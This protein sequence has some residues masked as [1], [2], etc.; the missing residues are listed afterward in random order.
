M[1]NNEE[2][3]KLGQKIIQTEIDGVI[4]LRDSLGEEFCNVCNLLL[5]AKGRVILTGMG[6]SG[7]IA[8]KITATMASTGTPALFVHP[9]EALHGDLGMI[10]KN[11]I[12]IAISNSG[13]TVELQ[14]IINYAIRFNIPLIGITSNKDS[15]LGKA[16]TYCLCLPDAKEAC[17]LGLAPTTSTTN[18]LVLGDAI[19]IALLEMKGFSPEDFR[20]FHPGGS[21]GSKLLKITDVM[22]TG[23]SIPLVISGTG[24][25][26]AIIE[27]TSHKFGCVGVINSS[28]EI[29]GII[30]DGDIRRHMSDNF[31]NK[32][33]DDVMTKKFVSLTTDTNTSKALLAMEDYKVT[34]LFVIENK[35]PVGIIHIHDLLKLGVM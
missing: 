21:L 23:D 20:V 33:V 29:V 27:I 5:N 35:K 17:S 18:T 2:I 30:T 14:G 6:K 28:G 9:A 8:T 7:H 3:I 13:N 25:D 11:D 26:K 34:N 22:H 16:S 15:D 31:L 1:F 32:I 10:E 24:M 19:S 12:I 4:A